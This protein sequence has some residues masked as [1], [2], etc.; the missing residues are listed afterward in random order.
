[1]GDGMKRL[2][3]ELS[4][5]SDLAAPGKWTD[6]GHTES[7][8]STSEECRDGGDIVCDAPVEGEASMAYW[9]YNSRFICGLVNAYRAG[10][11]VEVPTKEPAAV[12]GGVK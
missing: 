11:L 10:L 9:P 4:I 6:A 7:I 2:E 8:W 3:S 12:E 5:L 1:M